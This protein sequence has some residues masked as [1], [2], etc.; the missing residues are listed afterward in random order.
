MCCTGIEDIS[1][2]L[3]FLLEAEVGL[4]AQLSQRDIEMALTGSVGIGQ[5]PGGRGVLIGNGG[6]YFLG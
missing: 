3:S 5:T 4:P 1:L 2:F 6:V